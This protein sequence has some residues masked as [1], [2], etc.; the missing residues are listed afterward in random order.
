MPSE[1]WESQEESSRVG[2]LEREDSP[3]E[4]WDECWDTALEPQDAALLL[5]RP[6]LLLQLLLLRRLAATAVG[7]GGGG[8]G[9][10]FAVGPA[11]EMV[12]VPVVLGVVETSWVEVV[13]E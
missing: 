1:F 8:E 6:L 7:T 4:S 2:L 10:V 11:A 12:T 5:K 9:K 3:E 13:D